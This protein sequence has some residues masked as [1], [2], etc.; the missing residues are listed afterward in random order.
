[1]VDEMLQVLAATGLVRRERERFAISDGLEAILAGGPL[2]AALTSETRCAMRRG[3]RFAGGPA[4]AFGEILLGGLAQELDGLDERL[5][6][7]GAEL[8]AAGTG[9]APMA[10]ELCRRLPLAHVVAVD[11]LAE[12]GPGDGIELRVLGAED[13]DDAGRFDFAWVA[14]ERSWLCSVLH[15]LQVGGWAVVPT[16]S[17]PGAGLRGSVSR[18]QDVC[19]AGYALLPDELARAMAEAGFGSVRIVAQPL[20]GTLHFVAG[21]RTR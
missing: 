11:P 3:E 14:P 4:A 16:R 17:A 19:R 20:G 7:P 6:R 2:R 5:H 1:M 15:S 21:R 12:A 18:L 8:L 10:V 9:S 13:L